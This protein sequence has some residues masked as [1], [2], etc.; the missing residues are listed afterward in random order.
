MKTSPLRACSRKTAFSLLEILATSAI[1]LALIAICIPVGQGIV[2]R[3]RA[4]KSVGNLRQLASATLLCVNERNGI[5]PPHRQQEPGGAW[6]EP[7]QT[8]YLLDYLVGT[9]ASQKKSVLY[10]PQ[11]EKHGTVSDYGCNTLLFVAPT[12]PRISLGYITRP[13]LKVMYATAKTVSSGNGAWYI[14]VPE[15]L[16][17]PERSNGQIP[18]DWETGNILAAHVDGH[19]T[20]YPAAEFKTNRNDLLKI[21]E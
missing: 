19:V 9:K 16:S 21:K 11:A 13:G 10:D 18:W 3:A 8:T 7:L 2:R 12:A 17:D 15:F 5:F 14:Q 20:A 1:T 4:V 6:S